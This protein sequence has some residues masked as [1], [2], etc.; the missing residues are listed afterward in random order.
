MAPFPSDFWIFLFTISLTELASLIGEL[1]ARSNVTVS[2]WQDGVLELMRISLQW[3][4]LVPWIQH[5]HWHLRP[6]PWKDSKGALVSVLPISIVPAW[7]HTWLLCL[8][9]FLWET[10]QI[11]ELKTNPVTHK[12][13]SFLLSCSDFYMSPERGKCN[14]RTFFLSASI[15]RKV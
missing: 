8:Y 5:W 6:A 4:S 12:F 2:C 7:L 1:K 10:S 13:V 11:H 9:S 14:F 3:W 15:F